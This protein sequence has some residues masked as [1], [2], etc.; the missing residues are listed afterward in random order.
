MYVLQTSN[1]LSTIVSVFFS[2]SANRSFRVPADPATYACTRSPTR[3]STRNTHSLS[4]GLK[5][6]DKVKKKNCFPPEFKVCLRFH[7][8]MHSDVTQVDYSL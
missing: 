8:Q 6:L 5:D 7:S 1:I 3:G 2:H 4:L